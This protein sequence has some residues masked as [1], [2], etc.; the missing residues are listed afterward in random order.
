M[1][2]MTGLEPAI[3]RLRVGCIKPILLHTHKIRVQA[4]ITNTVIPV[5]NLF[6]KSSEGFLRLS[7][8][9]GESAEFR[10]S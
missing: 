3:P 9:T 7:R 6:Q 4:V 2:G 8:I 1:V 5:F 10:I